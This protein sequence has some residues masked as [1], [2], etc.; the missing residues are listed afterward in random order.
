MFKLF[1]FLVA[2]PAIFARTPARSCGEG[3]PMPTA[4]FFGSRENP[5]LAE[6]CNISRSGLIGVTY[7][8]FVV[9]ADAASIRPQVQ[10]TLFGGSVTIIQE[11]PTEILNN[12]CSIL[13]DGS[14]PL[15]AGQTASYRLALPV[16]PST[17]LLSTATEI[18]LFGAT[19]AHI[20]FCYRLTTQLVV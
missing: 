19:D 3:I 16:D 18:T 1:V 14:C 5:C 12:P 8:D 2:L 13:T 20:I 10:A 17:P 11:M 4:V 9:G 15:S 6:P 7:V